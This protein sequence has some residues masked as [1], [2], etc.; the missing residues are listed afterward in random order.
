MQLGGSGRLTATRNQ[1]GSAEADA[2]RY[3]RH[4]LRL[5]AHSASRQKQVDLGGRAVL[6]SGI[7]REVS[8]TTILTMLQE[9][10]FQPVRGE[11]PNA[12]IPKGFKERKAQ[13]IETGNDMF[14]VVG[15]SVFSL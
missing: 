14:V 9:K 3:N 2:L 15:E 7:P 5:K 13:R 6:L 11:L 4:P 1:Y 10:H 12:P 8:G